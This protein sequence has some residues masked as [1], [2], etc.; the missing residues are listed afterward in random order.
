MAIKKQIH[1]IG[2]GGTGMT[3]LANLILEK[4]YSLSGS[5]KNDFSAR[6]IL[7]KKGIK[8][9]IGHQANNIKK[10]DIVVYSSAIPN[11]N[12]ELKTA[13]AVSYTHL[14]AHETDSY[15]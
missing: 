12:I 10:A 13:E 11:D 2:I 5:D 6:K 1:L 15:L 4:G 7:E 8:I 3:A 9:Y 14:R